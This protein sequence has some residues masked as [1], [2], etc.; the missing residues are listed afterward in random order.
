MVHFR[1][2]F[3]YF[4]Y[5]VLLTF[6]PYLLGDSHLMDLAQIPGYT[7]K[8]ELNTGKLL[9][10]F[11]QSFQSYEYAG[12]ETLAAFLQTQTECKGLN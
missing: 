7:K 5:F 1:E 11:P 3:N 6:W 2:K 10:G 8:S 4:P 12:L 9:C